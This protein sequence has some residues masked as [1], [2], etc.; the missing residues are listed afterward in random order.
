MRAGIIIKMILPLVFVCFL[1]SCKE[2]VAKENSLSTEKST[3]QNDTLDNEIAQKIKEIFR[4]ETCKITREQ[5]Q[6]ADGGEKTVT[7]KCLFT[8]QS[9]KE[10]DPSVI[11]FAFYQLSQNNKSQPY[12]FIKVAITDNYGTEFKYRHSAFKER[13]ECF[14]IVEKIGAL[15]FDKKYSELKQ[16]MDPS[17][18]AGEAERAIKLIRKA[19]SLSGEIN[20]FAVI[21]IQF[22][23]A[24]TRINVK[25]SR[26]N[27]VPTYYSFGFSLKTNKILYIDVD[28]S[29][30]FP[31]NL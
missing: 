11:A 28:K 12:D 22:A 8:E 6:T 9:F 13:A 1:L 17:Q 30:P 23:P 5:K 15:L 29:N 24:V 3:V 10:E 25:A 21:S 19:D 16:Y 4:A 18:T 31:A 20:N 7:V 26:V 14:E 2:N 27:N